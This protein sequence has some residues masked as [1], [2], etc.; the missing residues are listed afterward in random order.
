MKKYEI[1]IGDRFW[2]HLYVIEGLAVVIE[3]G[4]RKG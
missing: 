4:I 1:V 3:K 2:G